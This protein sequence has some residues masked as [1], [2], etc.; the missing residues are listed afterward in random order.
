MDLLGTDDFYLENLSPETLVRN[1]Y[2]DPWSLFIKDEP[3]KEDKM[4]EGRFRLIFNTSIVDQLI[5][6]FL[7]APQN[8]AEIEKWYE[9]PSKPGLGFTDQK[10]LSII[11]QFTDLE[12]KGPLVDIDVSGWDWSFTEHDFRLCCETRIGLS[13]FASDSLGARVIRNRYY[14]VMNKVLAISDGSLYAQTSPGIMPSGWY[15]TTSDNTRIS[16]ALVRAA[17]SLGNASTG[18]DTVAVNTPALAETYALAGKRVKFLRECSLETGVEFC[19]HLFYRDRAYPLNV[20]KSLCKL[21]ACKAPLEER[22]QRYLQWLYEFRHHPDLQRL[23]KVVE[24]STLLRDKDES[25]RGI[26]ESDCDSEGE[27][28]PWR[29]VEDALKMFFDYEEQES[30]LDAYVW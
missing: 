19:S 9:L 14:C 4:K 7:F 15:N 16:T 13:G 26:P 17:G 6:K 25:G 3:H 10:L 27:S 20:S 21:F 23:K 11:D 28:K 29:E 30:D 8:Q 22:R 2:C 1:G 18:D 5:D 24:E 12:N